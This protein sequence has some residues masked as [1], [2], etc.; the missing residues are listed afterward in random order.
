MPNEVRSTRLAS[1]VSIVTVVDVFGACVDIR[2]VLPSAAPLVI[3][4]Q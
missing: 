2:N 3:R 1:S 4:M